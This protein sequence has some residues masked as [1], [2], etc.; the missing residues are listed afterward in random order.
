M[1]YLVF[2]SLEKKN[3]CIS[4]LKNKG[5]NAVF[6]YLSLH[7]SPYYKDK[8]AGEDMFWSNYYSDRLLRLPFYYE[9]ELNEIDLI[10]NTIKKMI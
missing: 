3:E 6:H 10:I 2:E 4:R 8:H 9:L 1:F 5:I 7:K